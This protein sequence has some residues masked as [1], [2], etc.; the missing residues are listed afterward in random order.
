MEFNISTTCTSSLN[1]SLIMVYQLDLLLGIL[2]EKINKSCMPDTLKKLMF[3][4][5]IFLTLNVI[6][7]RHLHRLVTT[8]I[9]EGFSNNA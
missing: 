5:I 4:K 8:H 7:F 2:D 9:P 1:M 6:I 3:N